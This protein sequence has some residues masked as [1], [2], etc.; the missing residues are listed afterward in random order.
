ML[1]GCD[2]RLIAGA[3]LERE[4]MALA[5]AASLDERRRCLAEWAKDASGLGPASTPTTM[6]QSSA[7]PL[8]ELLGFG[9]PAAIEVS[10]SM[11][12]ATLTGAKPVAL[13]VSCWAE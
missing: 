2:G 9:A 8:V 4:P 11:A 10:E 3:F 13:V 6:M 5:N 12:V 1:P 7:A